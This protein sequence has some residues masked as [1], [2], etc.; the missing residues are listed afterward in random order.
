MVFAAAPPSRMCHVARV[1]TRSA[2]KC[3]H[4]QL[5][6]RTAASSTPATSGAGSRGLLLP[7]QSSRK[8]VIHA[9][10]ACALGTREQEG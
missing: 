7:L 8:Y 6:G 5:A 10:C 3:E 1:L 2:K 9:A 4:A